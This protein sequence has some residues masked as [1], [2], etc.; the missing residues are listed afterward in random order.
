MEIVKQGRS[1]VLLVG[2]AVVVL[3][4]G[5][6]ALVLSR[7][8]GAGDG[9]VRG[10]PETWPAALREQVAAERQRATDLI[11]TTNFAGAQVVLEQ[12]LR[13][14]PDDAQSHSLLAQALVGQGE[15]EPAYRHA[16]RATALR[17][18]HEK[19]HQFAGQL[20]AKLGNYDQ[21]KQHYQAAADLA[22]DAPQHP[23]LLAA[24]HLQLDELDQAQFQ[25]LRALER[26]ASVHQAYAIVSQ[27]AARKGKLDM[28]IDQINKALILV[29]PASD[30]AITYTISKAQLLRRANRPTEALDAIMGLGEMALSMPRL[31]E[32]QAACHLMLSQPDDAARA[33]A[34]LLVRQ[35]TNAEAAAN[36]ALNY[37][38]ADNDQLAS[39]YLMLAERLKPHH[40]VVMQLKKEGVSGGEGG[41]GGPGER[42]GPSGRR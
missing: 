37:H 36:A 14:Y 5:V 19:L 31:V 33:W 16:A 15:L 25:A 3:V 30:R 38:R 17:P 42:P 23:L 10:G 35:P 39:H 26:D 22:P 11:H 7:G 28:A 24:L 4:V 21:A 9:V 34:E 13:Q 1:I 2:L 27:A 20:A 32:E 40:P 8:D 29:E 41:L 6:A 12:L 18:R